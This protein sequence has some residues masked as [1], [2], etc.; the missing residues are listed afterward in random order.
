MF[1]NLLFLVLTITLKLQS[2]NLY[3]IPI[4]IPMRILSFGRETS[5]KQW[6]V[7]S[8]ECGKLTCDEEDYQ[9]AVENLPETVIFLLISELEISKIAHLVSCILCRG[10]FR[11]PL[12]T[13][14]R[15]RL[16]T[17]PFERISVPREKL[18][19]VPIVIHLYL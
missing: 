19:P 11:S 8:L 10:I 13:L 17:S 9:N 1:I 16:G 6:Q 2:E 14:G 5:F 12:I 3:R 4:D 15:G 18:F 7:D